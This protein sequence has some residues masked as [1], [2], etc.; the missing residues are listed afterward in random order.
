MV[1]HACS[2]RAPFA[3][4]PPGPRGPRTRPRLTPLR[5]QPWCVCQPLT[6]M[7][8][9]TM[10]AM[11]AA[12]QAL[13]HEKFVA[14][15][16]VAC[17]HIPLP[18]KAA[19]A[20]KAA[21]KAAEAAEGGGPVAGGAPVMKTCKVRTTQRLHSDRASHVLHSIRERCTLTHVR[22][23]VFL[24]TEGL[25]EEVQCGKQEGLPEL[26]RRTL[27]WCGT[28]RWEEKEKIICRRLWPS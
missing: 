6:K 21:S 12:I 5:S 23:C 19:A 9:C 11:R 7:S 28:V 1:P 8:K 16:L 25:Q 26:P 24:L 27:W 18:I 3:G 4:K 22:L 2:S 10:Q 13:V 14:K 20:R 15:N 17:S